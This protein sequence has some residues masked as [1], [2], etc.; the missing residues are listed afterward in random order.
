MSK[1]TRPGPQMFVRIFDSYG[2][3]LVTGPEADHATKAIAPD[4]RKFTMDGRG[5]LVPIEDV[6]DLESFAAYYRILSVTYRKKESR[7]TSPGTVPG[8]RK[9][10]QSP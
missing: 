10:G 8:G 6:P 4:K 5:W 2:L 3:A 1:L 9:G 7:G